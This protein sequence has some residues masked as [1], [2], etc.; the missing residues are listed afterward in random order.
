MYVKREIISNAATRR[1]YDTR[2]RTTIADQSKSKEL[3]KNFLLTFE[4]F[5]QV[6]NGE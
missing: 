3:I 4:C 2:I 1:I 5:L 6:I